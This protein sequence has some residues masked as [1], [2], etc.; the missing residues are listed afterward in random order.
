MNASSK[1][2]QQSLFPP[3]LLALA[4]ALLQ[5]FN[6]QK[7]ADQVIERLF[8]HNKKWGARDRRFVAQALYEMVRHYWRYQYLSGL[9]D[10]ERGFFIPLNEAQAALVLQSYLAETS[11]VRLEQSWTMWPRHPALKDWPRL[12]VPFF[13][14]RLQQL[15]EQPE[16]LQQS[17]PKEWDEHLQ[18]KLPDTWKKWRVYL[19]QTAPVDLRVNALKISRERFVE[20][21]TLT[22]SDWGI[23]AIPELPWAVTLMERVNVFSSSAF[24]EGWFEVQDR[25]SQKVAALL[26]PQPGERVCD[27]CAGAGGKSLHLAALMK[28]QGRILA[29]D[30]LEYKL[31][32][33]RRRSR[34]AGVS[35]IETRVIDS[36][37]VI[38]RQEAKFDRLLLDVPCSGLG[39]VRRNPD[40][41]WKLS[42]ERLKELIL[43]QRHILDT[44]SRMLK[45]GGVM[46]YA[47]C[48]IHPDE[49][50]RQVEEFL[51]K[52]RDT[53]ILESQW[54]S[55][56]EVMSGD[57]FFAARL[58]K[59]GL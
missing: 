2:H 51:S 29:L 9:G 7:Y 52:N 50:E 44:Y 33:L 19:N 21:L 45:P 40:T 35:I 22:H 43:T 27:A 46:V 14:K 48:S 59:K 15:P 1:F 30:I 58:R 41:K 36:I 11:L 28:N 39:V 38:K 37:K 32:E 6:E 57:G 20:E 47:T 13:V 54:R 12:N 5:V 17:W 42:F 16:W 18:Q 55:A 8:L 34:R 10:T 25:A 56:P 31:T 4:Q 3:L 53:W 49:N 24:R 26:D 23:T